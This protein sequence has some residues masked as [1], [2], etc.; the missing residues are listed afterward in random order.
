MIGEKLNHYSINSIL[1][2]GGMATVYLAVDERFKKQVAIKVLRKEFVHNSNIRK[3]FLAEARSMFDM[4]HKN[5]VKVLDLID[6]GDIVAFIME[7]VD[8]QSIKEYVDV[9]GALFGRKLEDI[10]L[11]MLDGVEYVH[12]KGLIH[13]DIKPSNFLI[14]NSGVVKLA[15]FGIAKST[16]PGANEYTMTGTTQQMGTPLYMSPEQVISTKAVTKQTDIYSLGVVLW[17]L[18][19]GKKPYDDKSISFFELQKFIVEKPLSNTNTKFDSLIKK[20]C[21]KNLKDRTKTISQMKREFQI[22][23]YNEE[24]NTVNKRRNVL[25][26]ASVGFNVLLLILFLFNQFFGS[27]KEQLVEEVPD[28]TELTKD[29]IIVRTDTVFIEVVGK[30]AEIELMNPILYRGYTNKIMA[31]AHGFL[32]TEL[33]ASGA[34]V[35]KRSNGWTIRP[36]AGKSCEVTVWGKSEDENLTKLK[37]VSFKVSNLPDPILYWG[38]KKSGDKGNKNS[39]LLQAKYGPGIPLKAE[40]KIL[41]W[42]FFAPGLKGMTPTGSGG[43]IGPVSSLIRAVKPGHGI[44]FICDVKGPD[45]MVRKVGA[46]WTL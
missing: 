31:T 9:N 45:G 11:Q 28:L 32:E 3:R 33:T 1:G 2:E 40:F 35:S 46:A 7:Y 14:T 19:T 38:G 26:M 25:I 43:N 16:D 29:S 4:S 21:A 30:S 10:F 20:F 27:Q 37:T 24:G 15:D 36:G 39:N 44:S 23:N 22:A 13:R 5:V 34:S 8:G 41:K 42:K 12:N 18:L 17:F 6:A